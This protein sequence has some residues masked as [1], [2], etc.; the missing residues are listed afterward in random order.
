MS[1]PYVFPGS[2]PFILD[3]AEELGVVVQPHDVQKIQAIKTI[4]VLCTQ[5]GSHPDPG[6]L[7]DHAA[8]HLDVLRVAELAARKLIDV[9]RKAVEPEPAKKT[10]SSDPAVSHKGKK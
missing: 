6:V 1:E 5:V 7:V 3:A 9:V 2:T 10:A 4:S 8:E